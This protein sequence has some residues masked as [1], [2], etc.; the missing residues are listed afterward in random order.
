ML[1]AVHEE[2]CTNRDRATVCYDIK[3]RQA[4]NNANMVKEK[5]NEARNT[6]FLEKGKQLS[7][8]GYL[9]VQ[10]FF[11]RLG[12]QPSPLTFIYFYSHLRL[13]IHAATTKERS[14]EEDE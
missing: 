7:T 10:L 8:I 11:D 12:V 9:G 14:M 2:N 4:K 6:L 13:K 3:P 5:N 1:C